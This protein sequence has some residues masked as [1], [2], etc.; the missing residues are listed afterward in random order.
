MAKMNPETTPVIAAIG[1]II[2]RPASPELAR[3]PNEYHED[4]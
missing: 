4:L 3:E 1:E 2:D